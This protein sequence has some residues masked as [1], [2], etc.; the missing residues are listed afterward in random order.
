[1]ETTRSARLDNG[2]KVWLEKK[3][4]GS[5]IFFEDDEGELDEAS[6]Q[7]A[8]VDVLD[9]RYTHG[10]SLYREACQKLDVL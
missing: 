6:G 8:P 9:Y 2:E 4:Y 3:G 5:W 10:G 7:T 1:M